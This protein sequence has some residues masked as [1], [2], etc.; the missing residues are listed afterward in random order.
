[1]KALIISLF[2]FTSNFLFSQYIAGLSVTQNGQNKI[3][4][5]V[6]AY[7][8]TS[9]SAYLSYDTN[10]NQNIITL[11]AC[12]Y[13]SP[14]G[15]DAAVTYYENDFYIDVP[16][17]ATYTLITNMYISTNETSCNYHHI[18]DTKTLQFTTPVQG[19]VSLATTKNENIASAV[20]LFPN[21]TKEVLNF[22]SPYKVNEINMYDTS[23]KKVKSLQK[24]TD[25]KIDTSH[26][27]S[28]TYLIEFV[29][30]RHKY[31]TKI[32]IRK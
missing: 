12:Y 1:M 23:G 5:H 22:K 26:F 4:V 11:N 32:L 28:G 8:H 27:S 2:L 9:S 7:F 19:T 29:G 3:K 25:T 13:L 16:D 18:E 14:L 10:T 17:Q 20:T 21:P 15:G 24:I 31:R 6:K 30:D